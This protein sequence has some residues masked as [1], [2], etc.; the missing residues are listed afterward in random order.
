M[1]SSAMQEQRLTETIDLQSVSKSSEKW[2]QDIADQVHGNGSSVF[3]HVILYRARASSEERKALTRDRSLSSIVGDR[4]LFS[5]GDALHGAVRLIKYD[6]IPGSFHHKYL[7]SDFNLVELTEEESKYPAPFRLSLKIY[8]PC[9]RIAR[10][11]LQQDLVLHCRL[12]YPAATE[13]G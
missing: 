11:V 7:L 12:P 8:C 6:V 4:G 2:V 13:V 5:T 9:F 1:H 10:S 3:L